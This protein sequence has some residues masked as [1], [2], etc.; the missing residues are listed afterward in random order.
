MILPVFRFLLPLAWRS[1]YTGPVELVQFTPWF[2]GAEFWLGRMLGLPAPI[3]PIATLAL[4]AAV[5]GATALPAARRLG[6]EVRMWLV[7]YFSYLFA[8][9]FPQ[10]STFRL[11]MPMFPILGALAVPRDP[12]WRIGALLLCIAGQLGWLTIC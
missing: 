12:V 1:H 3:A 5:F 4:A 11:L 7:S 10:S 6:P 8:V 9:F 2:H